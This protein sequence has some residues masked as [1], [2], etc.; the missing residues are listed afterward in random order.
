MIDVTIVGVVT[1]IEATG[2]V[3]TAEVATAEV[4]TGEVATGEVATDVIEIVHGE[5]GVETTEIQG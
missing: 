3:A 2:E 4:A 5:I 1:E